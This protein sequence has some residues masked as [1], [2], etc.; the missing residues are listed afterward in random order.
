[1]KRNSIQYKLLLI[2]LAAASCVILVGLL[3]YL[4]L[5]MVGDSFQSFVRSKIPVIRVSQKAQIY[6][7]ESKAN[8]GFLLSAG[9]GE[10]IRK[11]EAE[12]NR[13]SFDFNMYISAVRY[14]SG[15]EKFKAL[16]GGIIYSQWKSQH[17]DKIFEIPLPDQK[18]AA[19]LKNVDIHIDKYISTSQQTIALKRKLLRLQTEGL[20][21]EI[22]NAEKELSALIAQSLESEKNILNIV[23]QFVA[24]IDK[25]VDRDILS[26]RKLVSSV[27]T[28]IGIIIGID[29]LIFLFIEFYFT[30]RAIIAPVKNLISV[31]NDI[32]RGKLD[33]KIETSILESSD[34]IGELARAF[35]RI[36]ISLKLAMRE[37]GGKTPEEKS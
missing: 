7:E 17:L 15:S 16:D 22:N 8:L 21:E 25:T 9:T 29:L 14:G 5:K 32:S 37:Q 26:Q 35:D 1:M 30:K 4:G 31:V 24:D 11:F 3:T 2:N 23:N 34:E 18:N 6:L 28:L 27:Y 33:A 36:V 19:L 13:S 10:G 20:K 12:F